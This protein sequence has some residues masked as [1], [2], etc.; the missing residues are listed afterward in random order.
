MD[1][2]I[3]TMLI[4]EAWVRYVTLWVGSQERPGGIQLFNLKTSEVLL[5]FILFEHYGFE[6][7]NK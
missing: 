7:N 4:L 6:N 2:Y 3:F 1:N 5:R